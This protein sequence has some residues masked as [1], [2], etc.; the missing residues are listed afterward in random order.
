MTRILWYVLVIMLAL[1]AVGAQLD[2]QTRRDPNLASLVPAPFRSF[3]QEHIVRASLQAHKKEGALREAITL[4]RRRPVP[5]ENLF[6]LAGAQFAA[7]HGEEAG[8]ALDLSASRGWRASQVQRIM[9]AVALKN[10][11]VEAASARL[12]ALWSIG[13]DKK[14]LAPFTQQVL[15]ADGG[16]EAF[17]KMVAQSRFAGNTILRESLQMSTAQQYARMIHA[18][19]VA[20]AQFDCSVVKNQARYLTENG[21]LVEAALVKGSC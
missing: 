3:A 17:G 8:Q 19:N 2:R 5:A 10:G 18:A 13:T 15:Q 7:G 11:M 6:L 1:I 9:I 16:P 20:G 14:H 4:V 12:L 21:F